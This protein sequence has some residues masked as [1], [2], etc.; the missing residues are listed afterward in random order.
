MPMMVAPSTRCVCEVLCVQRF[1]RS[2]VSCVCRET[3]R[4]GRP[5]LVR[6][7]FYIYL[8]IYWVGKLSH[9]FKLETR[10]S[11]YEY[12]RGSNFVEDIEVF[13]PD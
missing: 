2:S 10:C 9:K 6:A 7:V 11:I 1:V 5:R 3:T 8:S 4:T 12:V 13:C